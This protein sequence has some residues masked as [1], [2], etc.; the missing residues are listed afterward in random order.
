MLFNSYHFFAFFPIVSLLYCVIPKKMRVMWL[1]AASYYFYMG[2]NPKYAILI[3]MCT[4]VT[5]ISAYWIDS[6]EGNEGKICYRRCIFITCCVF[7]F[8]VLILFKYFYFLWDSLMR[9]SEIWGVPTKDV[10]FSLVLP[11]GISFYTFQAIGYVIDVYQRKTPAQKNFLKYALFISFFPKLVAGPIERTKNLLWQ[12]DTVEKKPR[13]NIDQV[14]NGL[15]YMLYGYFLKMVLADNLVVFVDTIFERYYF[16]G[17]VE[18]I[19]AAVGFSL[20]IYCDFSSYSAIAIGAAEVMGFQ[21]MENFHAPYFAT[22]IQEFWRRWHISLSTW[23]KDYLYIPLGGSKCSKWKNYRNLMLTFLVSG[24]WHGADWTYVIWGGIHGLYQVI[25]KMI[26]PK[27]T[28]IYCFAGIKVESVSYRLGQVICTF[29]LTTLAWIFFR[30]DSLK[31]AIDYIYSM[32]TKWNLWVLTDGSLRTT[33]FNNGVEW[34]VMIGMLMV[35]LMVDMVLHKKNLRLD[36]FLETQGTTCRVIVVFFLVTMIAIF[37][38]Y[39]GYEANA[40]IYVQ[41]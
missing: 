22:S 12:I 31:M 20:Q 41:F 35:L 5:Y 37:G 18:L 11:V 14:R 40:F 39:G 21:L 36:H 4:L 9:I 10:P 3:L 7:T 19:L 15:V 27:K 6:L 32:F 33:G 16:Y 1:L 29:L 25:G 8:G 30:A 38:N 17:A 28:K 2:W 24:L 23:F 13:A 26:K 34:V